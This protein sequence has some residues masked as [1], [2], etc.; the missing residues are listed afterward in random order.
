MRWFPI[1]TP[2]LPKLTSDGVAK[3]YL[4]SRDS[5]NQTARYWAE[6]YAGAPKKKNAPT[7]GA[8]GTSN[9]SPAAS[10]RDEI[11]I[12][13]LERAHVEQFESLGFERTKVVSAASALSSRVLCVNGFFFLVFR[14]MYYDG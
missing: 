13:G 8:T 14:L 5:F 7:T 10:A 4:S 12:A 11:A 3:H 6:I 2:A 1:F 9:S